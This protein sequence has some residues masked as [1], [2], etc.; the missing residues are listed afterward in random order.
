MDESFDYVRRIIPETSTMFL[1]PTGGGG[2]FSLTNT[3]NSVPDDFNA[4]SNNFAALAIGAADPNRIVAAGVWFRGDLDTVTVTNVTIGGISATKIAG[5]EVTRAD[6]GLAK[7]VIWY[8]AVP[9]GTIADVVVTWNV[10]IPRAGVGIYRIVTTTAVPTNSGFALG[11]NAGAQDASVAATVPA[12]GAGFVLF[13]IREAGDTI[14]WN[15]ATADFDTNQP[16][17][18][19][20]AVSG[21]HFSASATVGTNGAGPSGSCIS[22]A[23]WQP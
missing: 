1:V 20:C 8:A 19:L 17:S 13:G 14:T 6:T 9:T 18:A 7:S 21:A 3:G 16:V 22:Y 12:S 4:S 10:S 15:N 23:S 5:S 2:S 11:T